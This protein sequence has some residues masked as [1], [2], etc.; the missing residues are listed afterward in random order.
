MASLIQAADHIAEAAPAPT[1]PDLR[2]EAQID[3]EYDGLLLNLFGMVPDYSNDALDQLYR[4]TF[5]EDPINL[6]D[7]CRRRGVEVLKEDGSPVVAWRDILVVLRAREAGV[8]M[9]A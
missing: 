6:Y 5:E 7:E 1:D 9:A 3:P 8:L 4:A 2:Y